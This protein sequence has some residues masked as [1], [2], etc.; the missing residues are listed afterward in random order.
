M[1]SKLGR[2]LV[3]L[4]LASTGVRAA[5]TI[6]QSLLVNF[7]VNGRVIVQ[8][9]EE[10]GKFPQMLFISE[11]TR[12]ALLL[13]SIEDREKWLIPEAGDTAEAQP[14]LRFRVIHSRGF[15]SP[16]VMSVGLFNGGSD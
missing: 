14:G 15:G 11:K 8:A 1:I 3:F 9:R 7:P 10:V 6:V 16:L 4:M 5:P 12:Q 13:S 2:I